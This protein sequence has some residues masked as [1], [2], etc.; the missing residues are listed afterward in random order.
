MPEQFYSE[1]EVK[2]IFEGASKSSPQGVS[3][4]EMVKMGKEVG[5]SEDSIRQSAQQLDAS[6]KAEEQAKIHAAEMEQ[7]QKKAARDHGEKVFLW[8]L[9]ALGIIAA[10]VITEGIISILIR[11]GGAILVGLV[12]LFII[13]PGGRSRRRRRF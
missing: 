11:D 12:F 6:K 9:A 3:L 7:A 13:L 8:V 1:E 4:D 10:G 5:Y 2:R